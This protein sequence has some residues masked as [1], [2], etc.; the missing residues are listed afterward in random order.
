[1][2]NSVFLPKNTNPESIK[3]VLSATSAVPAW[4]NGQQNNGKSVKKDILNLVDQLKGGAKAKKLSKKSSK[5]SSKKGSKKGSKKMMMDEQ[6]GGA[7][8]KKSSKKG[9]KKGS[10]KLIEDILGGAK[11]VMKK[12][13]KKSSKKASKKGSKKMQG[14]GILVEHEIAGGKKSSKKAS[15]KGS[16][17]SSKKMGRELP[18]AIVK[19][20]EFKEF[21]QKEMNLKGGPVLMTFSYMLWNKFKASNPNATPDELFKGAMDIYNQEKKKGNLENLYK[22]AE[23]KFEEKKAAKKAAKSE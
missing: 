6:L 4:L 10:K 8:G 9:S 15:K 2:S 11:K 19:G 21:V 1:M 16:K 18:P 12:A 23:K 17:K 5:K 7:W 14:G 22:E 13:S 20:N 3:D